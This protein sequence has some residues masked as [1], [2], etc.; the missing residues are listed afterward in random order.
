MHGNAF[1]AIV[2]NDHKNGPMLQGR[3]DFWVIKS[4]DFKSLDT[5]IVEKENVCLKIGKC[6]QFSS[7]NFPDRSFRHRDQKVWLDERDNSDEL[8]LGDSTFQVIQG[9][10]GDEGTISLQGTN[11]PKFHLRH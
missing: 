5:K 9:L 3:F 10:N 2:S 11:Y 1:R 7:N 4:P 8:F 6:Y